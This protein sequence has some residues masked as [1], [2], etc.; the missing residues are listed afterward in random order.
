MSGNLAQF[1]SVKIFNFFFFFGG[2]GGG[3]GRGVGPL[4]I[5]NIN[6]HCD[7][8]DL[9]NL[10][11]V[12]LLQF[13]AGYLLIRDPQSTHLFSKIYFHSLY[14]LRYINHLIPLCSRRVYWSQ[15]IQAS[16]TVHSVVFSRWPVA[17][18]SAPIIIIPARPQAFEVVVSTHITVLHTLDV[19]LVAF[20]ITRLIVIICGA[21]HSDKEAA[22]D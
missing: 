3:K 17:T 4:V 20:V 6:I 1:E 21:T 7:W 18:T 9:N 15:D 8:P 13:Q 5:I 2:G 22:E 10:V 14:F 11:L 12:Y 19:V 16:P